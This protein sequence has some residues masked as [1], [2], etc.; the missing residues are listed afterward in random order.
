MF[1]KLKHI[2]LTLTHNDHNAVY[3][4]M[5]EHIKIIGDDVFHSEDDILECLVTNEIWEL[6]WHPDTPISFYYVA[7]STLERV[8]EVALKVQSEEEGES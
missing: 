2:E 8:I 3:L 1:E 6:T 7:A 4:S 5:A